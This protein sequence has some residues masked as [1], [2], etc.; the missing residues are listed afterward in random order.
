MAFG[1]TLAMTAAV[2]YM[3]H[4]ILPKTQ[5]FMILGLI[6]REAGGFDLADLGGLYKNR[7]GLAI[8][9]LIG[10]LARMDIPPL[11]GI[12]PKVM[13]I[14]TGLEL[15]ATLAIAV[16]LVYSLLTFIPLMRI[17]SHAFWSP[18]TPGSVDLDLGV[19]RT[20]R[21][22]LTLPAAGLAVPFWRSG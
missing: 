20:E 6:G 7:P 2:F 13:I 9:F 4:A 1:S 17:W 22:L 16:V 15:G 5:L 14:E 21:R 19:R 18:G 10:A 3:V 12:W 8:I 11:T